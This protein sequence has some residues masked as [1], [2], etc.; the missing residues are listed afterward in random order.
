MSIQYAGGVIVNTTFTG[1]VTNDIVDNVKVEL[2]NAG[3]SATGASGDWNVT[4][5]IPTGLTTDTLRIFD[6]TAGT[7]TGSSAQFKFTSLTMA[8]HLFP[9]SGR[10]FRVIANKHQFF[11]LV[12]GVYSTSRTFICGGLPF[13]ET[14]MPI[15][16]A[17]WMQGNANSGSDST[18]RPSFRT[19]DMNTSVGAN[20]QGQVNTN[21]SALTGL[22]VPGLT[23]TMGAGIDDVGRI[24]HGGEALKTAARVH[25]GITNES[26]GRIRMQLWDAV[27]VMK[28]FPGDITTSFDGHNWFNLSHNA[29]T[30]IGDFSLWVAIT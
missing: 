23:K 14:F 16:S 1:N 10:V 11:V 30:S 12:D 2:V 18:L 25:I 3:W 15:T 22:T 4:P 6:P 5:A 7:A 17:S 24:W 13:I 27:V 29:T 21:Q 20:G 8:S 19:T 26:F 28:E 9:T